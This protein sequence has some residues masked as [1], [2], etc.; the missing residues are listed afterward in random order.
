MLESLSNQSA[1]GEGTQ[2]KE[3]QR[4]G[5][6]AEATLRE[7]ELQ[8]LCC[9]SWSWNQAVAQTLPETPA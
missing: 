2:S 1:V 3:L 7:W 9:P 5:T 8:R 6:M 4:A